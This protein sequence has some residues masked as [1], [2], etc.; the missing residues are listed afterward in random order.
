VSV[1]FEVVVSVSIKFVVFWGRAIA[2]AVSRW[3]ASHRSGP[4]SNPGRVMWDLWWTKWRWGRFF[5]VFRFPL[6]IFIPQFLRNHHP[7]R[8]TEIPTA[9]IK[10]KAVLVLTVCSLTV[11]YRRFRGQE[12]VDLYLNSPIRLHGVVLN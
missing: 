1:T 11:G 3:L 9:Q 10:K 2:Q 5:R 7:G 12:N 4:G 8:R 6:P